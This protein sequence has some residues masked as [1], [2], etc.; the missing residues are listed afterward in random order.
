MDAHG[1]RQWFVDF[2]DTFSACGRGDRDIA[3]LLR[4][5]G[6][7]MLLTSDEGVIA[8]ATDEQV[9]AT[10]Q[11]QIEGLRAA[12]FHHSEVLHDEVTIL[13]ATSALLRVALSR[14]HR[15]GSELLRPTVTYL[16]TGNESPA[17]LR[18][19]VLAVNSG[20]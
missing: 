19:S 5:Y 10:I 13:N 1:V 11:G 9:A 7:P 18:I 4:F 2:L 12:G 17:R 6:V 8:L 14:L 15:D 16:L 3:E 20:P